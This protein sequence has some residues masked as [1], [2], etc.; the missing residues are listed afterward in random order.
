MIQQFLITRFDLNSK[1]WKLDKNYKQIDKTEWLVIRIQLFKKYCLPSVL[2]QKEKSFIWIIYFQVGYEYLTENLV[3]ELSKYSF[4]KP[5]YKHDYE[6]FVATSPNDILKFISPETKNIITTRLDNDDMISPSFTSHV[7]RVTSRS[8]K[9]P[10]I[11]D[12]PYGLCMQ[13][14]PVVFTRYNHKLNQFISYIEPLDAVNKPKTVYAQQHNQWHNHAAVLED[15]TPNLWVQVVHERNITNQLEGV[16]SY[17]TDIKGYP[18]QIV[19]L[20]ATYNLLIFAMKCKAA[21][22]TIPGRYFLKRLKKSIGF[23]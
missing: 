16:L 2:N 9:K 7:R 15:P 1:D 12:F 14:D 5:I 10:F 8:I 17:S 13:A 20:P 4:I 3:Q 19:A 18:E 11:L 21:F 6:D 23:G 22:P